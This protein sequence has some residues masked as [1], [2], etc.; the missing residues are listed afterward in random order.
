MSLHLVG[1]AES[2]ALRLLLRPAAGYLAARRAPRLPGASRYD[3]FKIRAVRRAPRPAAG[4]AL[5]EQAPPLGG[6]AREAPPALSEA[7]Q[8]ERSQRLLRPRAAVE[9]AV[10]SA[11]E[12]P[13][14]GA[15]YAPSTPRPGVIAEPVLPDPR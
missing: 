8:R 4:G 15:V 5:R 2:E 6:P 13:R 9:P 7:D 1:V 14:A 11:T 10:R 12:A 3:R